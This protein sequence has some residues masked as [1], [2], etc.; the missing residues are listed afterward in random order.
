MPENPVNRGKGIIG[1]NITIVSNHQVCV[2]AI[3]AELLARINLILVVYEDPVLGTPQG[4]ML[5][6]V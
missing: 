1:I 2:R 4:S 3:V 5:R 6:K